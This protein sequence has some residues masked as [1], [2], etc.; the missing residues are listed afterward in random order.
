MVLTLED[1]QNGQTLAPSTLHMSDEEVLCDVRDFFGR[2]Q[3]Y[4]DRC[5]LDDDSRA[6]M[7][8]AFVELHRYYYQGARTSWSNHPREGVL[9]Q[10][11]PPRPWTGQDV[12]NCILAC[13]LGPNLRT[14]LVEEE[15]YL[16]A[17]LKNESP[18]TWLDTED[19]VDLL[20]EDL[21]GDEAKFLLAVNYIKGSNRSSS[22]KA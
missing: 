3:E 20:G 15:I 11:G 1:V 14:K 13:G 7:T 17:A 5:D 18:V 2:N 12:V 9:G 16:E 19:L 8:Q 21:K 10:F 22:R 4:V 6:A